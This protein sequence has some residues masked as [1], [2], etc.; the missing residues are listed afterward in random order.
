MAVVPKQNPPSSICKT[1]LIRTQQLKL[2]GGEEEEE[3]GNRSYIKH[4]S[5][6]FFFFLRVASEGISYMEFAPCRC[7]CGRRPRWR[8][9][10]P[11]KGGTKRDIIPTIKVQPRVPCSTKELVKATV[12]SSETASSGIRAPP[13]AMASPV[14]PGRA[15]ILSETM[16]LLRSDPEI[17]IRRKGREG[18][19][20]KHAEA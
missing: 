12:A 20:E 4:F 18:K 13:S 6:F 15:P 9:R 11:R 5:F 2:G 19:G 3:E 14:D 17:G 16:S 8:L 10:G 1:Q 7:S